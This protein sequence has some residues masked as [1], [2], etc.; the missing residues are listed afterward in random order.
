MAS[1][2]SILLFFFFY[3]CALFQCPICQSGTLPR[4]PQRGAGASAARPLLR[5]GDSRRSVRR[6]R[7]HVLQ[8]TL[9][10]P[11]PKQKRQEHY[12]S[13]RPGQA[14]LYRSSKSSKGR[15]F[16]GE[17]IFLLPKRYIQGCS[18]ATKKTVPIQILARTGVPG[19]PNLEIR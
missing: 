9:H 11:P 4:T 17:M 2:S 12:P 18:G 7:K 3:S 16:S 1:L 14:S 15:L 6:E 10:P 13:S 8:G 19:G 5:R